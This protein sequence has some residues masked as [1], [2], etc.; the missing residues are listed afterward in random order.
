M[1]AAT[2][3]VESILPEKSNTG[4]ALQATEVAPVVGVLVTSVSGGTGADGG[5]GC[6]G[7]AGWVGGAAPLLLSPHAA[8]VLRRIATPTNLSEPRIRF[9]SLQGCLPRLRD[10]SIADSARVR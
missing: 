10:L 3:V 4:A 5:V 6:D 2:A 1:F 8:R 9:S 7:G